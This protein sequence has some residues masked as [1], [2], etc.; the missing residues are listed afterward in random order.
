VIDPADWSELLRTRT[1]TRDF[2]PDRVPDE[3]LEAV[4]ADALRA[5]SWSNTLPFRLAIATGERRDRLAGALTAAADASLDPAYPAAHGEYD[6][7]QQYPDE[8]T[9]RRRAAGFGLYGV[10]GIAREDLLARALQMRR[11]FEFFGAPTAIFVYTHEALGV[12]SVLDAGFMLEALVLAAHVRG[13]A[14]CAQGALAMFPDAVR[15]EFDV[16]D[17]YRLVCGIALGYASDHPVNA[18]SPER[19]AV[20]AVTLPPRT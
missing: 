17:G 9:E 4:I 16:P 15:E 3:V 8:F 6:I 1:S 11:N 12:Y 18:F 14:T 13:L 20:S 5:P 10:L 7:P 19:P 2:R